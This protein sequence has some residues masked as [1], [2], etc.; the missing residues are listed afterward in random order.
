V[1][2]LDEAGTVDDLGV[3]CHVNGETVQDDRTSS[4]VFPAAAI[5]ASTSERVVLRRGDVID[6]HPGQHRTLREVPL[7]NG[8]LVEVEVVGTLRNRAQGAQSKA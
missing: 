5:V 4:M 3:R 8:E 1:A 6:G 2:T 7:R